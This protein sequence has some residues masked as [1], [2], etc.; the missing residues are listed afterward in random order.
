[1]RALHMEGNWGGNQRGIKSAVSGMLD[2]AQPI[3]ATTVSTVVNRSQF[4]DA[5]GVLH[6]NDVAQV[7][8]TGISLG[9]DALATGGFW[10]RRDV[11]TSTIF[12]QVRPSL[13]SSLSDIC[14]FSDDL[15]FNLAAGATYVDTSALSRATGPA[16]TYV[17]SIAN[18]GAGLV[19]GGSFSISP[20]ATF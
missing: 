15:S 1:M 18:S 12:V 17:A 13:D 2:P 10:V 3:S 6:V 11:D 16:L 19:Q 4:I 7:T 20:P 8:L 9:G 14:C 5:F